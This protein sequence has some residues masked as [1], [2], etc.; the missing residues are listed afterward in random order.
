MQCIDEAIYDYL[1]GLS[2]NMNQ[3][4]ATPTNPV[5]NISNNALGYFKAQTSSKKTINVK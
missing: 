5:S 4:S 1:L 3:P 2:E